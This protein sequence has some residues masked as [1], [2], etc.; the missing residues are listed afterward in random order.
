MTNRIIDF[1]EKLLD[2]SQR[3]SDLLH[4]IVEHIDDI[5]NNTIF[6]EEIESVY[7]ELFDEEVSLIR[8]KEITMPCPG[9]GFE[10]DRISS[11]CM[12]CGL[13]L[14]EQSFRDDM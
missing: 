5:K 14:H 4:S 6:M 3:K 10:C 9:C 8:E 7:M 12:A 2:I 11:Y 1:S 13:K